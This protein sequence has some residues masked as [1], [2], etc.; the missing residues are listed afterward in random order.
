MKKKLLL[1]LLAVVCALACAF[2]L[3]ACF[4]DD[5]G[6]GGEGGNGKVALSALSD[7]TVNKIFRRE[8]EDSKDDKNQD[9]F[10]EPK[11]TDTEHLYAGES[12]SGIYC[13][14]GFKISLLSLNGDKVYTE[15]IINID[16][17]ISGL[18]KNERLLNTA[19]TLGTD[20]GGKEENLLDSSQFLTA[21]QEFGYKNNYKVQAFGSFSESDNVAVL[22]AIKEKIKILPCRKAVEIKEQVVDCIPYGEIS[23]ERF[24][25]TPTHRMNS[26]YGVTIE[27]LI[28][29]PDRPEITGN[30]IIADRK[31]LKVNTT[32]DGIMY[33]ITF[34]LNYDWNSV[35]VKA[36]VHDCLD[37]YYSFD[38]YNLKYA[39]KTFD[40]DVRITGEGVIHSPMIHM[41]LN[42]ADSR[43]QDYYSGDKDIYFDFEVENQLFDYLDLRV[44]VQFVVPDSVELTIPDFRVDEWSVRK[45]MPEGYEKE[46]GKIAQS[47]ITFKYNDGF[48]AEVD[49]EDANYKLNNDGIIADDIRLQI[50]S[51][52]ASKQPQTVLCTFD[53]G[54][55]RLEASASFTITEAISH[56]E[57]E[58]IN[59]ITSEYYIGDKFEFEQ[60]LTFKEYYYDSYL[61]YF[62]HNLNEREVVFTKEYVSDF[63]T[64]EDGNFTLTVGKGVMVEPQSCTK[65]N[66]TVKKNSVVSIQPKL[67]LFFG[68]VILGEP[69]DLKE[70]FLEV[71]YEKGNKEE[72]PM[73][74][75]MLSEFG[76]ETG[77]QNVTVTYEGKTAQ[78]TVEVKAVKSISVF[79][80]L[81]KYYMVTVKPAE[82]WLKVT[83]TDD[84]YDYIEV[85]ES[86]FENFDTSSEGSKQ[87]TLTYGGK[88]ATWSYTVVKDAYLSYTVAN[89]AVTINGFN[90]GTPSGDNAY[91][92]TDITNINIPAEIDGVA[93]TKIAANAFKGQSVIKKLVMPE[94]IL[95]IGNDAFRNCSSL[96][97]LNIPQTVTKMGTSVADGCLKLEKLTVSGG[98]Q[99]KNYFTLYKSATMTS[100]AVYPSVSE[101]L[102]VVISG[103]TLCDDFLAGLQQDDKVHIAKLT[104]GENLTSLGTQTVYG[105]R[106]VADFASEYEI[107]KV[108]DK[109]VYSD[110][111]ATLYYYPQNKQDKKFT[112]PETV[113]KTVFI[114]ENEFIEEIVVEGD[115]I[116]LGEDFMDNCTS[117]V[118]AKFNGSLAVLSTNAFRNCR[119]MTSVKFPSGLQEI[120]NSAFYY[121][122]LTEVIIPNTVTKVGSNAFNFCKCEKL[123]IPTGATESFNKRSS[124]QTVYELKMPNLKTL[125]YDGSLQYTYLSVY[126]RTITQLYITGEQTEVCNFAN[127]SG[128]EGYTAS[129]TKIYVCKDFT[130]TTF[131][132]GY[133]SASKCVYESSG[134]TIDKWWL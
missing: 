66:Y 19:M 110:G 125:A 115:L 15:Q 14:L 70:C 112:V 120:G 33:Q 82:V 30:G 1:V 46:T 8:F 93:V 90:I 117:L 134:A 45:I 44:P 16:M 98:V 18:F 68:T 43:S 37:A 7:P 126:S 105:L 55:A 128:I 100:K 97:E 25:W 29:S 78:L 119:E 87:F 122:S 35:E 28:S 42:T 27:E 102:N 81:E 89:G 32:V 83:F 34:G 4:G 69:V 94:G 51:M 6:A 109:V 113:T 17:D 62:A 118:S 39:D 106:V 74:T 11:Y 57:L 20:R 108:Q 73:T 59:D 23:V 116:E 80:G 124:A 111:G 26:D 36:E 3:T 121:T 91:T 123:Y 84:E 64:A 53:F 50:E 2:G 13:N 22:N 40:V 48:S 61:A 114:S 107:V 132:R 131:D 12:T 54:T 127:V 41:Q 101:T 10:A 86:K 72:I 38:L 65:I 56:Y 21:S 9:V 49:L 52:Q 58:D 31:S 129:V 99:L 63:S 77:E 96:K 103:T 67:S 60:G 71:T 95:E 133:I 75:E 24:K 130:S 92:L 85:P 47:K 76:E 104:F 88:T 5:D 79:E